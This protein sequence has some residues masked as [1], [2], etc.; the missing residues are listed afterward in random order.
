MFARCLSSLKAERV[1][2]SR[3]LNGPAAA[4]YDGDRKQMIEDIRQVMNVANCCVSLKAFVYSR[5]L[6]KVHFKKC[7][8]CNIAAAVCRLLWLSI[9]ALLF[10]FVVLLFFS[11]LLL[12]IG[13]NTRASHL[14]CSMT[15]KALLL[16][17]IAENG[18]TVEK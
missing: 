4:R 11:A 1:E 15:P 13:Q 10:R 5:K 16:G 14:Y 12:L 9:F 3:V 2:A 7:G 6:Q 18:A 8:D 17:G